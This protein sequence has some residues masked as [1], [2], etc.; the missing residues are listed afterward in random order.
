VEDWAGS[1]DVSTL[2]IEARKWIKIPDVVAVVA[3]LRNST[4]LGTDRWAAS[5]ASIYQAA[6]GGVVEVL[7]QFQADFIQIQGDGAFG[8]FWGDRRSPVSC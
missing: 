5:T 7:N 1:L 8:L 3:D 2:P 4:Q 6:T